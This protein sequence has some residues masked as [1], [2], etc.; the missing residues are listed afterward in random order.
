MTQQT[1]TQ[2]IVSIDELAGKVNGLVILL[3]TQFIGEPV[4]KTSGALFNTLLTIED[5]VV[6]MQKVCSDYNGCNDYLRDFLVQL[7]PAG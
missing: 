5:L 7:T 2:F 6:E 3:Q 4:T 1:A